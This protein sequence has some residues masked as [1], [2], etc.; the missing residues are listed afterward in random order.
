MGVLCDV[1]PTLP[2]STL[3]YPSTIL[4]RYLS[5]KGKNAEMVR[6][7]ENRLASETWTRPSLVVLDQVL[8]SVVGRRR[9]C[10][11]SRG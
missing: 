1:R 5:L 8:P 9:W 4:K 2:Y 10:V 6:G 7:F 11:P 3:L